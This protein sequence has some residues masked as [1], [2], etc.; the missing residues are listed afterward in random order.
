MAKLRIHKQFYSDGNATATAQGGY[1][2]INCGIEKLKKNQY[3]VCG[4][5]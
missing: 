1:I 4:R 5:K 2:S 3:G